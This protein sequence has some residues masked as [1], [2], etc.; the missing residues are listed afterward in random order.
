MSSQ[1][2]N[3]STYEYQSFD[4]HPTAPM[5]PAGWDLSEMQASSAN[6]ETEDSNSS[7]AN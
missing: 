3:P 6:E 4:P 5:F 7:E 1:N 2:E